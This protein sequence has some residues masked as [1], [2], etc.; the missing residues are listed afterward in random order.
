[1]ANCDI[2]GD[3]RSGMLGATL[4]FFIGFAAVVALGA[5]SKFFKEGLLTTGGSDLLLGL[6]VAMPNL[7]GSLLRIPF[8]AWSDSIGARKPMIV[9][10]ILSV[11]G[12]LGLVIIG[13]V[14][15]PIGI[16]M[17]HY[18]IL[19]FLGLLSGCGI[20]TF[21]VGISQ[22]SYW[23]PKKEQG[24]AL[25]IYAGVGNLAPGIFSLI[26]AI[27]LSLWGLGNSYMLWF[28]L[29]V[30]GTIVYGIIGR[31][32][33]S[34][35]LGKKGLKPDEVRKICMVRC[36]Q[37]LFPSHSLKE[38]LKI[39]I[40]NSKTWLLIG[41]YFTSFGGFI[42]LAAWLPTYW[43]SYYNVG[44]IPIGA[45]N[46]S[47]ALILTAV[48]IILG[49]LVRVGS[50]SLADKFSGVLVVAWGILIIL[51]GS[52]LTI[53]SQPSGI[54]IAI[55]GILSISIGMGMVNAGVFKMVPNAVPDAVGG[56]AGWIGGLGAFGGFVI[57]PLL[58][59]FVDL[60]SLNGYSLGFIIFTL[61]SVISLMLV[62]LLNRD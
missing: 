46:I 8:A 61:L 31:D 59:L 41:L 18:P 52:I 56:A 30:S 49:S 43:N 60:F 4:G 35:Q 33:C 28:I 58:G 37:D 1:M 44:T 2:K 10:L 29:L 19:L 51:I 45:I 7:S 50:G 57:P 39:S 23:Y 11:I 20:A 21:S 6:L 54:L 15:Y 36:D 42:A 13:Y 25:G 5:T 40:K 48:F 47:V 16:T 32:A 26:M 14:I 9:L 62:Y 24:K 22:V 55:I 3:R 34:F 17:V 38:S 27:I 12:L 53:L